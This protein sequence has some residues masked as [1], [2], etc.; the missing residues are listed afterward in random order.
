M[1]NFKK[2]WAAFPLVMLN[3]TNFMMLSTLF[4]CSMAGTPR[5]TYVIACL[6]SASHAF[7]LIC[8]KPNLYR[9]KI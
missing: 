3:S 7:A 1:I 6:T 9:R 4:F 5:Y 2:N 8:L